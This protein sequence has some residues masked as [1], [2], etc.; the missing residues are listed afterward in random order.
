MREQRAKEDPQQATDEHLRQLTFALFRKMG[1]VRIPA[2]DVAALDP[3]DKVSFGAVRKGMNI[4]KVF[5][6]PETF[7][8]AHSPE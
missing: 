2:A 5:S 7:L 8:Q 6:R 3:R 4:A 1:R